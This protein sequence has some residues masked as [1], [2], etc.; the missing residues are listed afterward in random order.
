MHKSLLFILFS[1]FTFSAGSQNK[2]ISVHT[3][4]LYKKL[5]ES[6]KKQ[7]NEIIENKHL[8]INLSIVCSDLSTNL[9]IHIIASNNGIEHI[10]FNLFKDSIAA[11]YPKEA[12][13][14]LETLIFE[15]TVSNKGDFIKF[16]TESKVSIKYGMFENNSNF[17]LLK[18]YI[19]YNNVS[20]NFT[21]SYDSLKYFAIWEEGIKKVSIIFPAKYTLLTCSDKK[22][23]DELLY[24]NL[25]NLKLEKTL[26]QTNAFELNSSSLK[27]RS[28]NVYLLPGSTYFEN[29]TTDLYFFKADDSLNYEFLFDKKYFLES[30]AN[31]LLKPEKIGKEIEASIHQKQYGGIIK[32]FV[33]DYSGLV[34]YFS[35]NKYVAYVGIE[36]KSEDRLIA[37]VIFYNKFLNNLHLI[38]LESNT[39]SLFSNKI[40]FAAK[41]YCNIPTDNLKNIFADFTNLETQY[42]LKLK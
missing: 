35:N 5:P 21:L 12:C 23:L 14:F 19:N 17:N 27:K 16:L 9:P 34:N 2:Y 18:D 26:K 39:N 4:N 40:F 13:L 31:L 8:P 29:I 25:A 20:T 30:F 36:N 28:K 42:D 41:L 33:I 24:N 15:S 7:I 32:D 1:I 22:E 10:G 38:Y 3:E 37:T 11:L 6:C